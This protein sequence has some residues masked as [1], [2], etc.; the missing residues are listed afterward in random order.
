MLQLM[1]EQPVGDFLAGALEEDEWVDGDSAD[2]SL[3][4]RQEVVDWSNF[5][6][7]VPFHIGRVESS[8]PYTVLDTQSIG[9]VFSRI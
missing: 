4:E 1:P 5:H 6:V 9:L 3:S 7:S 8:L 2:P